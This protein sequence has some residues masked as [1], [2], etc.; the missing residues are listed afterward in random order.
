MTI[1]ITEHENLALRQLI[2]WHSAEDPTSLCGSETGPREIGPRDYTA[3][4]SGGL[5]ASLL[6]KGL[7]QLCTAREYS[8]G[9]DVLVLNDDGIEA[10]MAHNDD[11]LDGYCGLLKRNLSWG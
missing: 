10:T 5:A 8:I 2:Q 3:Q 7:V 9:C 4:Q 6:K 1:E 11:G